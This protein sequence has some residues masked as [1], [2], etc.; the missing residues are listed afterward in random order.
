MDLFENKYSSVS[1]FQIVLLPVEAS[2][3]RINKSDSDIAP[4]DQV[5]TEKEE[6]TSLRISR[7]EL[8]SD[9]ADSAK[10]TKVYVS[11]TALSTVVAAI[12]LMRNNIAVIIGVMV[13][14]ALLP[15]LTVCGLMFGA[16]NYPKAIAALLLFITNIICIN[17]AGVITFFL[18]GVS[19]RAWWE[20]DKARRATRKA[21]FLWSIIL[22][23]LALLIYLWLTEL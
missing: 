5:N 4:F 16:G 1:G 11:L 17:L 2:L 3:P 14:V 6:T 23:I 9:I 8:Y 20:V 18:Q 7:E 12:G 21:F 13:A 15:P 10:L 19:P 22:A